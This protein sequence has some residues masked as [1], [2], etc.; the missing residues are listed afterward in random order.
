MRVKSKA[1]KPL[2]AI[3]GDITLSFNDSQYDVSIEGNQIT[4]EEGNQVTKNIGSSSGLRQG[5]ITIRVNYAN[6][7]AKL[8]VELINGNGVVVASQTGSSSN[9]PIGDRINLSYTNPDCHP[10]QGQWTIRFTN[11]GDDKI[12]EMVPT[13][14]FTP[15]CPN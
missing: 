2:F 8:K 14:K 15:D 4:I 1:G 9:T 3:T 10:G 11:N 6:K 13:A 5:T 12:H 7:T